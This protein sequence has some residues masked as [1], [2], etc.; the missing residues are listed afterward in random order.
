MIKFFKNLFGFGKNKKFL[1]DEQ[2]VNAPKI[3]FDD[4]DCSLQLSGLLE[5]NADLSYTFNSHPDFCITT[6]IKTNDIDIIT[7]KMSEIRSGLYP[8]INQ[9]HIKKWRRQTI[10]K[11]I[12]KELWV[13]RLLE[14]IEEVSN[15][16]SNEEEQPV[17]REPVDVVIQEPVDV[18]IQEPPVDLVIQ[19][20]VDVVIQEPVDV[21]IQEP[22]DL[23]IQKEDE[24]ISKKKKKKRNKNRS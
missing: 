23:V 9:T 24:T 3:T 2:P 8:F 4:V 19:E 16:S 11:D 17:T 13:E 15:E 12:L 14:T 18:V 21:V 5:Q 7:K 1:L 20:P 22:V 6:G 10:N